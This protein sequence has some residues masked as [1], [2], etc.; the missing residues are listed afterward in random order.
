MPYFLVSRT[1]RIDYDE[2]DACVVKAK[3][4]REALKKASFMGGRGKYVTKELTENAVFHDE[5]KWRNVEG[6]VLASF[7]AG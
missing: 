6:L 1:D 2:Y 4:R 7:N 3:N 5:W